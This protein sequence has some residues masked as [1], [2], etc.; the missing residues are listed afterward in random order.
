MTV[1][2]L[3]VV[4]GVVAGATAMAAAAIP[5]LPSGEVSEAERLSAF[6]KDVR[7]EAVRSGQP[8][9]L[10][11]GQGSARSG[12]RQI[13]WAGSELRVLADGQPVGDYRAIVS[14]H[15]VVAG[16]ELSFEAGGKSVAM[17]GVYRKAAR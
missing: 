12:N 5:K 4:L 11:I 9:L 14:T 10:E 8:L 15:G 3:V 2:E 1:L 16:A 17:R 13:I 6:V 7:L